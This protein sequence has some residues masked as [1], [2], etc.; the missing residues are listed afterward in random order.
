MGTAANKANRGFGIGVWGLMSFAPV[1][2]FA[3]QTVSIP[4]ATFEVGESYLTLHSKKLTL[5][6]HEGKHNRYHQV[7]EEGF[8]RFVLRKPPEQNEKQRWE[9]KYLENYRGKGQNF[10]ME[11]EHNRL[12]GSGAVVSLS[13]SG[14][15]V[16]EEDPGE[17]ILDGY[18]DKDRDRFINTINENSFYST[19]SKALSFQA[20]NLNQPVSLPDS[21]SEKLGKSAK[22]TLSRVTEKWGAQ[23]AEFTIALEQFGDK[24]LLS[25][26]EYKISA[27]TK[28]GKITDVI[29]S[30]DVSLGGAPNW[31]TGYVIERLSYSYSSQSISAFSP[32]PIISVHPQGDVT[33]MK[34]MPEA[35]LLAYISQGGTGSETSW[36]TFWDLAQRKTLFTK[37]SSGAQLTLSE[38]GKTL[39]SVDKNRLVQNYIP[40]GGRF[41]PFGQF[42]DFDPERSVQS[43]AAFGRY[44]IVLNDSRELELLNTG[45]RSRI[46]LKEQL[47]SAQQVA[48]NND[49][50]V[51]TISKD[52]ELNLYQLSISH[53]PCGSK[54]DFTEAWCEKPD[55]EFEFLESIKVENLWG[56]DVKTTDSITIDSLTLHPN[57]PKAIYCTQ[58]LRKCGVLDYQ[59]GTA[60]QLSATQLNFSDDGEYVITRSGVFDLN[61][62][63]ITQYANSWLLVSSRAQDVA[64]EQELVFVGGKRNNQGRF[65]PVIELL[66]SK[67]GEVVD[68]ITSK[69]SHLDDVFQY[70]SGLF[71]I[72]NDILANRTDIRIVDLATFETG[73][74]QL[75]FIAKRVSVNQ[76]RML[77]M[78]DNITMVT[79]LDQR[80]PPVSIT[81][82]LTDVQWIDDGILYVDDS[83][84]LFKHTISTGKELLIKDFGERVYELLTLDSKGSTYVVMLAKSRL[85]FSDTDK[86]VQIGYGNAPHRSLIRSS[87]EGEFL[88]TGLYELGSFYN[89]SIPLVSRFDRDGQQKDTL[90]ATWGTPTAQ[91][92]SNAGQLWLGD[93]SGM[94]TIRNIESGVL[95]ESFTAHSGRVI[96]IFE[97]SESIIGT[98]SQMGEIKFWQLNTPSLPPLHPQLRV[99]VPLLQHDISNRQSKLELTLVVDKDNEMVASTP[100]GYY[101]GTPK[102]IH[103]A[104][105]INKETL[106]D[107]R[108]YDLWLNRPD[109]VLERLSFASEKQLSMWQDIVRARQSRVPG[110]SPKLSFETKS[111]YQ[112]KVTGS[113]PFVQK[114]TVTLDWQSDLLLKGQL[115]V[116][117]NETPLYG[118][119]GRAI[120]ASSGHIKI[121]LS[122]GLNT[123]RVYALD[124]QGQQTR[125]QTL[126]YYR[127]SPQQKPTLYAVSIGVS[128]YQKSS[129]NLNYAK[130][131]AEDL[132]TLLS[133]SEEFHRVEQLTLYDEQVVQESMGKVNAFLSQAKPN[134]RV[135]VFF[136]G[137]GFLD[138]QDNYYFGSHDI[139]P[140]NPENRGISYKTI[141]DLLAASP[142]RYKLLMLDTCHSGEVNQFAS[143]NNTKLTA[144]VTGRGFKVKSRKPTAQDGLEQ[145]YQKLQTSFVDL[146]ASTGAVVISASGGYEFALEKSNIANGV[147]TSAVLDA[148]K[149]K[150][151][152]AN[153]D[154]RISTSE[155]RT[156]TYAEVQRLTN[157]QQK[158]TTRSY[159]LDTDF[160][161]F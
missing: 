130:K 19:L 61:G 55:V 138:S 82:N 85:A 12:M 145:S 110:F 125:S 71:L 112:F 20:Y 3:S 72:S 120:S 140:E 106:F 122:S 115:H 118:G 98:A 117:V 114:D 77:L 22:V 43:A 51:L 70:Q 91:W 81:K 83:G 48:A 143:L 7:Q 149:N 131:D 45:Y 4:Q 104:S 11:F 18:D 153:Q 148:L 137:H 141:S 75:P 127:V 150:A 64:D 52:G 14:W 79:S 5:R 74:T 99:S 102:G 26:C 60:S 27:F 128:D 156:Y 38:D 34:F 65:E 107:Y 42:A 158:P 32:E 6:E 8:V 129:L 108:R 139:T 41:I 152:D 103:Q 97:V 154:G 10:N 93:D 94:V 111:D 142:S 134:D 121:E 66:D 157:G 9:V 35:G 31:V 69:V 47:Q 155:L 88:S 49:G 13:E 1:C 124:E 87:K 132:S 33:A 159:N 151:A 113:R 37:R 126:S 100:E 29:F 146:R 36:L 76:D 44:T 86:I 160:A 21:L 56:D 161:V 59:T 53:E 16:I 68:R 116:T 2:V 40:I 23:V 136:A 95:T 147:F 17:E 50:R 62:K 80:F 92:V 28:S 25:P 46:T 39:A 58:E 90:E 101:W 84:K 123:I 135:I 133:Q 15:K 24:Q 105:F 73:V 89:N 67:N 109:L 54:T 144:G 63:W 96:A 119:Q 57:Q 78:A 30:C